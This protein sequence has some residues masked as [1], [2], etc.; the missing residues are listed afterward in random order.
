MWFVFVRRFIGDIA[1]ATG[2]SSD[3]VS[4]LVLVTPAS[5]RVDPPPRDQ[6]AN[7]FR[8]RAAHLSLRHPRRL[9][10]WKMILRPA[11]VIPIFRCARALKASALPNMMSL[12]F[13]DVRSLIDASD[14]IQFRLAGSH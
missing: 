6:V 14:S 7:E 8:L 10:C 5:P 2:F 11:R 1:K 4:C 9:R 3:R 13:P 12:S